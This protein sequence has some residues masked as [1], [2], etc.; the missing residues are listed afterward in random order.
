MATLQ[1]EIERLESLKSLKQNFEMLIKRVE[2]AIEESEQRITAMKATMVEQAPSSAPVENTV[3]EKKIPLEFDV[4]Y[5]KY[6]SI[7]ERAKE[8]AYSKK[9]YNFYIEVYVGNECEFKKL[10]KSWRGI[11]TR[12]QFSS[13]FGY[14]LREIFFA[15]PAFID[16]EYNT[17]L[18]LGY[19]R[20]I[21]QLRIRVCRSR[22][23]RYY[24]LQWARYFG[25]LSSYEKRFVNNHDLELPKPKANFKVFEGFDED[26]HG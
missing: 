1:T 13:R 2:K 5:D 7:F 9:L 14:Y 22:G 4:F 21:S 11:Y 26:L 8:D 25:L 23:A 20:Y 10:I 18:G 15:S 6:G 17:F 16:D 19:D 12:R 24:Y 3:E